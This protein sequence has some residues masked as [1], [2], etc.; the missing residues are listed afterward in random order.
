VCGAHENGFS[1]QIKGQ[2]TKRISGKT[3]TIP[4][5]KTIVNK[6]GKNIRKKKSKH[7]YAHS[8]NGANGGHRRRTRQEQS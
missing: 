8:E 6:K 5:V 3:S 2:E 4:T 7:T 1:R